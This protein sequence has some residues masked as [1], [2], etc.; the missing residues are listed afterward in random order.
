MR[1]EGGVVTH[2]STDGTAP[3]PDG[4]VSF[5][6]SIFFFQCSRMFLRRKRSETRETRVSDVSDAFTLGRTNRDGDYYETKFGVGRVTRQVKTVRSAACWTGPGCGHNGLAFVKELP[7]FELGIDALEDVASCGAARCRWKRAT[8][9]I[10]TSHC[11]REP[12]KCR[13]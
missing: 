8:A 9:L 1:R 12:L 2:R 11:R 6:K 7:Q 5:R 4:D 10:A 3:L 13:Q